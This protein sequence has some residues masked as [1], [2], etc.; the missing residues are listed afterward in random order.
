MHRSGQQMGHADALSRQLLMVWVQ[1]DI[2]NYKDV[3][4]IELYEDG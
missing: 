1:G 4:K 3:Y 2:E